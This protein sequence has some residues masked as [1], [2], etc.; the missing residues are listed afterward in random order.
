[1]ADK[2]L[3]TSQWD[4]FKRYLLYDQKLTPSEGNIGAQKSRF[5]TMAKWFTENKMELNRPNFLL[6]M[7]TMTNSGYSPAQLNN[8]VKCAKHLGRFFH[9]DEFRDLKY[10]TE[11]RD[12]DIDVLTADEIRRMAYVRVPY[13]KDEAYINMRNRAFIM[14]A[15]V[16]GARPGELIN[17]KWVDVHQLPNYVYLTFKNTKT[18]QQRKVTIGRKLGELLYSLP[19]VSDYVFSSYRGKQLRPQ[20]LNLDI[21]RRAKMVGIEKKVW[22]H[23]FRHSVI[24]EL[25]ADGMELSNVSNIVGHSDPRT[26]LRYKHAN[27]DQLYNA[28]MVHPFLRDEM[29]WELQTGRAQDAFS[30]VISTHFPS[31]IEVSEDEVIIR[32]SKKKN[33]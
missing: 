21:K 19:K 16:I 14:I 33:T 12:I 20:E 30:K 31:K 23:L 28:Q 4:E 9:T 7:E 2:I 27:T 17:L 8:W 15:G 25:L 5:M 26:T 11:E 22:L 1:M 29:T 24:T 13:G 10:F 3:H 18:K 32:I 6:F